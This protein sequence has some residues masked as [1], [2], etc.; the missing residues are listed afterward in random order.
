[1]CER[2]NPDQDHGIGG[3][4]Q[5]EVDEAM[6]RDGGECSHCPNGQPSLVV[7]RGLVAERIAPRIV[8][9]ANASRRPKPTIPSSAR[10]CR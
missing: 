5:I 8:R 3:N 2:T 7:E 1:M 10:S 9:E 6:K 4:V